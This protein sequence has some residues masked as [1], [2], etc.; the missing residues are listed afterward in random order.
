MVARGDSTN[1]SKAHLPSSCQVN[2][3]MAGEDDTE[4]SARSVMD[5]ETEELFG[6]HVAALLRKRA[7]NFQRDKK[8]WCCTTI[9][10]VLF[11]TLGFML[12]H[13]I[14]PERN[15]K[16]IT[17]DLSNLNTDSHPQ[18]NPIP[19]NNPERPYVCQPGVCSYDSLVT[20]NE[21]QETYSFCGSHGDIDGDGKELNAAT[22]MCSLHHSASIMRTIDGFGGAVVVDANVS[23]VLEVS[24]QFAL[25]D[26]EWC[27]H[28][29]NLIAP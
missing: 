26:E 19:V 1:V 27:T 21:T 20:V 3:C 15:L 17:L 29:D 10:P 4:K 8:A 9:L 2:A 28:P 11:V 12:F 14:A 22:S 25:R 24:R 18:I 23:S 6:R 13:F 16:P 5:L 7:F